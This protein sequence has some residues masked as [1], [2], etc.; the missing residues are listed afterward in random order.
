MS[1]PNSYQEWRHCIEVDCRQPLTADYIAARLAAL[2]DP[3]D[4]HTAQFLE[5]YGEAR[6]TST[7]AWFE[8]AAG[9]P[10]PASD[11]R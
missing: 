10:T 1:F 11:T 4:P 9:H 8:Q 5:C 2:R 6:L 7:I 3:R